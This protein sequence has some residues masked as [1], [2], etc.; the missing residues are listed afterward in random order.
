MTFVSPAFVLFVAITWLVHGVLPSRFRWAGLLGASL[1]F[2]ATAA[3]PQLLVVLA[4]VTTVTYLGG[5]RI[6]ACDPRVRGRI[7]VASLVGVFFALGLKYLPLVHDA[8]ALLARALGRSVS[9]PIPQLASTIGI[10]YFTLQ[11][12][13]YLTDVYLDMLP[14]ERHFGR[15][16]LSLAFFPKIL[17]GPIERGGDLLPQ[18][19]TTYHFDYE[20]TRSGLVLFTWGLFKKT[21]AADQLG[22]TVD[23]VYGNVHAYSGATLLIA[24]YAYA[25]QIYLDFAAYTDMARGIARLFGI[26]LTR[27]FDR[28]YAATSVAEFWRRWHLSFSRWLLDYLFRPLQIRWRGWRQHGTAA[29]ILA[30][31]LLSGLWH[32]ATWGF[33]VWGALHGCYQVSALYTRGYFNRLQRR[34]GLAGTQGLAVLQ[35]LVTFH[36]VA[37][38]WIF[39]RAANLRDALHVVGNLPTGPVELVHR[40]LTANAH[41]SLGLVPGLNRQDAVIGSVAV[42]LALWERHLRRWWASTHSLPLRWMGY[43]ALFLSIFVLG[44][45][46]GR[47]FIYFD[48]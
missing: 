1:I 13:A 43:G 30:T 25:F 48:F 8:V 7:Y 9:I 14:P 45:F 28:P 46:G 16:A 37:F 4:W 40:M 22:V 36:L 5:L 12:I 33:L 32:G 47:K 11:A 15:L 3:E 2:Y 20:K 24:T 23:V 34:I 39:F 41:S 19:E 42:V 21:V 17:Q 35:V 6:S 27:N 26:E 18:L 31:F 38:A 44:R 10:S 29:A